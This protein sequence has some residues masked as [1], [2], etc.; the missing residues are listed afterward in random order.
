MNCTIVLN[1]VCFFSK[2]V[3]VLAK[4]RKTIVLVFPVM[5]SVMTT[6]AFDSCEKVIQ[7]LRRQI[8]WGFLCKKP[9]RD[10]KQVVHLTCV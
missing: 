4:H 1:A 10:E 9:H 6:D 8:I 5:M 7:E 3:P 2:C